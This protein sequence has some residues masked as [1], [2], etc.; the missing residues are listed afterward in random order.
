MLSTNQVWNP[1]TT[2]RLIKGRARSAVAAARRPVVS[3]CQDI[4]TELFDPFDMLGRDPVD[5]AGEPGSPLYACLTRIIHERFCCNRGFAVATS[6][7]AGVLAVQSLNVLF[8][9]RLSPS[10]LRS[11]VSRRDSTISRRTVVNNAG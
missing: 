10:R 5:E 1:S 7:S 6:L 2:N 4:L 8:Q 11:P 9:V 3:S